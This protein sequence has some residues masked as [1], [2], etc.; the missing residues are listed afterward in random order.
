[1][2]APRKESLQRIQLG[3]QAIDYHLR[4]STRRSVGLSV[5]RHGL[6]VSAPLRT[7]L[8]DI[9]VLL[10]KHAPWVLEKLSTRQ[11]GQ[12][13]FSPCHGTTL[14]LFGSPLTLAHYP[15][16]RARWRFA[17]TTLELHLPQEEHAPAVLKAA[18]TDAGRKFF[19][20]R[21]DH[22][23][24]QLGLA[25]PPLRISSARTRWGS[26]SSR[27]NISLSWRLAML[28]PALIDY[29]VCHELAH[30]KEMNHSPRFWS[31]VEQLCPDWRQLR[32][33]L[34]Q[35]EPLIPDF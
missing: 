18:L 8:R 11:S 30:L 21:L 17:G 6:R 13:P 27:G 32:Q 29:I 34:R 22:Y 10:H 7:P 15:A 25:P 5:D 20:Q 1:M 14:P 35:Q 12:P 16:R 28:S 9:E 24:P 19:R 23:A 33:A 4:R 26:C 2:P 31:I 3:E